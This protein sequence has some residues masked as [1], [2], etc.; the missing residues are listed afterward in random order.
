MYFFSSSLYLPS[1]ESNAT[2][3]YCHKNK[4]F[5]QD[6][7]F[8]ITEYRLFLTSSVKY[9]CHLSVLWCCWL[10]GRKGIRPV[11]NWVVV[12]WCGYLSGTRCRLAYGPADATHCL[13]LQ[14]IGFTFMVL[15]HRGNS[16]KRAV[17]CVHVCHSIT[18]ENKCVSSTFLFPP[19][20][21]TQA[22]N[23][24]GKL[25]PMLIIT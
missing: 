16:G 14:W 15:A 8:S 7:K 1:V 19:C 23:S 20:H 22:T 24:T 21:F 10:G 4:K 9:L 2:K 11:K 12:C 18:T 17:K 5:S 25:V 6:D 13:M 3:C